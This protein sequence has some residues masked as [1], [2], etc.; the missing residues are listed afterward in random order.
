M[1]KCHMLNCENES[2]IG[3]WFCKEHPSYPCHACQGGGCPVCGGF[4]EILQ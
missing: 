2:E 3:S 1:T 4:G